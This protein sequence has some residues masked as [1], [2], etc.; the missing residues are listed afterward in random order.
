MSFCDAPCPSRKISPNRRRSQIANP[1]GRLAETSRSQQVPAKWLPRE[2]VFFRPG[3][4]RSS[5]GGRSAVLP[6]IGLCCQLT[7]R[8]RPRGPADVQCP[9]MYRPDQSD[10]T[11]FLSADLSQLSAP[12]GAGTTRT[13]RP[14]S[15]DGYGV[16]ACSRF[17]SPLAQVGPMSTSTAHS[18]FPRL[19]RP[20]RPPQNSQAQPTLQYPQT[21]HL[22]PFSSPPS[23][24]HP[25]PGNLSPLFLFSSP[26]S[27][28]ASSWQS[29][30]PFGLACLSTAPPAAPQTPS[31]HTPSSANIFSSA[32]PK[33]SP[34][35]VSGH[36]DAG[37]RMSWK[38]VKNTSKAIGL[39]PSSR[40]KAKKYQ[41]GDGRGASRY[42]SDQKPTPTAREPWRRA[43][44][45]RPVQSCR[46]AVEVL[47]FNC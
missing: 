23:T 42:T 28:V 37:V 21:E 46:A 39:W 43:D 34:G 11:A 44:V 27:P 13:T 25:H 36:P 8:L 1:G 3:R 33:R 5:Q 47:M 2:C 7:R 29:A 12:A 20:L 19:P 32:G 41:D 45:R 40:R 10:A 9:F 26:Q 30:S 22:I 24:R 15:Q 38:G 35:L 17:A 14:A 16:C 18:H 6:V 4:C 31:L